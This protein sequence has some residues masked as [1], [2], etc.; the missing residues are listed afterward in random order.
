MIQKLGDT[1]YVLH[2]K[3]TGFGVWE[4]VSPATMS[5]GTQKV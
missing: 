4:L 5:K 1:E 2:T 3:S